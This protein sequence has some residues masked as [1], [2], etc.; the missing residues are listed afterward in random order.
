MQDDSLEQLVPDGEDHEPGPAEVRS[1]RIWRRS[2][3]VVTSVVGAAIVGVGIGWFTARLSSQVPLSE[4]TC[5]LVRFSAVPT[6]DAV[7]SAFDSVS[8]DP[9][10]IGSSGG[11]SVS[12]QRIWWLLA[13]RQAAVTAVRLVADSG[14]FRAMGATSRIEPSMRC[15]VRR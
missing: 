10:V 11:A 12:S 8:A 7:T 3:W 5:V 2:S 13:T 9:T 1:P 14:Q 6:S 15:V 4:R